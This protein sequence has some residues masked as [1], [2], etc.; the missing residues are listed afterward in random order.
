MKLFK[1]LLLITLL[2]L[3][4]QAFSHSKLIT[5]EPADKSE[6]SEAPKQ[7]GLEYNREVRLIKLELN[8]ADSGAIE[9]GFRPMMNKATKFTIELPALT[10]GSYQAKW[11]AMGAD[12]H[13]MEGTFDFKVGSETADSTI[14]S[15]PT[16]TD[17]VDTPDISPDELV[18]HQSPASVT[19]GF[20]AALSSGSTKL[21]K[22]ITMPGI[23]IY[24]EGGIESSFAEYSAGHL[25]SD[26]AFMA[27]MDRT[28]K[29]QQVFE[30]TKLATVITHTELRS[31][32]GTQARRIML[33][34]MVLKKMD[35]GW[36]IAHIHWSS[37]KN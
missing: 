28:V 9:M 5:S 1:T 8:Q 15:K 35:A 33:E 11:I 10:A 25:T 29:S 7:I 37:Q 26:I 13:K 16:A 23:I 4:A 22:M 2:L 18:N 30:G 34:T 17:P 27:K 32:T 12:S 3:S 31:K 20:A 36:K 24:E 21:I 6:L 14:A 19:N